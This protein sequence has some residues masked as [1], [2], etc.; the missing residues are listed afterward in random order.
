VQQS[1]QQTVLLLLQAY[2]HLQQQQPLQ[3]H[4]QCAVAAAVSP[5]WCLGVP[6]ARAMLGGRVGLGGAHDRLSAVFSPGVRRPGF[7]PGFWGLGLFKTWSSSLGLGLEAWVLGTG[8]GSLACAWGLEAGSRQQASLDLL[9]Q[10]M[11]PC[12]CMCV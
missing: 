7:E 5:C 1:V 6:S 11:Y 3:Q 2:S 12:V 8:A 9:E 4:E 10:Q